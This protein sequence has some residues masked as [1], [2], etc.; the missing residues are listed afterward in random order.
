[1]RYWKG[2][3]EDHKIV[4][5]VIVEQVTILQHVETVPVIGEKLHQGGA[6]LTLQEPPAQNVMAANTYKGLRT[7]TLL[8]DLRLEHTAT[9]GMADAI[10]LETDGRQTKQDKT[11]SAR[12]R[13]LEPGL[14]LNA[15]V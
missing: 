9:T 3:E 14:V 2:I 15:T 6:E 12:A 7:V 1:M 4:S 13:N 11:H 8:L 5:H 10:V